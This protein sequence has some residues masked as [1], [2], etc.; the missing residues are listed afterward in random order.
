VA[1][2]TEVVRVP[3]RAGRSNREN[4]DLPIGKG[5]PE[6]R[7][8]D[9]EEQ[10]NSHDDKGT[11][12]VEEAHSFDP[13]TPVLMADGTTKPIGDIT[14]GDR[15]TTIDPTTAQP[16]TLLHQNSDHDLTDVTPPTLP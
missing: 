6:D 2:H 16:V 8:P 13:T 9:E 15:V 14:I 7:K 4:F 10:T 12:R 1:D 5:K 3:F 11:C